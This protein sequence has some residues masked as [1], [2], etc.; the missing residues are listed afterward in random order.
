MIVAKPVVPNQYWILRKEDKKVGNI[1]A[2]DQGYSIRIDN[3]V[4]YFKTLDM[5]KQRV[6]LDFELTTTPEPSPDF[7]VHGFPTTSTA[8]NGIWDIKRQLPLWTNEN[9]SKSWMVAGWFKVKQH[10]TWQTVMCPKLIVLDR[11]QYRGPFKT[12]EEADDSTH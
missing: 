6:S 4:M 9:K 5:L 1:Q 10:R 7:V 11:Y 2:N 8:F 3:N 12:K